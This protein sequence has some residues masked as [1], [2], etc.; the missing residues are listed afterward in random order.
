MQPGKRREE[1]PGTEAGPTGKSKRLEGRVNLNH[2][3]NPL[4]RPFFLVPKLRLGE[5]GK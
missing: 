4:N 5:L 1:T 2:G 3:R